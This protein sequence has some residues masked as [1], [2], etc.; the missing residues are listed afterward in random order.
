MQEIKELLWGISPARTIPCSTN[1]SESK[2]GFSFFS[3]EV[4]LK[5][6]KPISNKAEAPITLSI[7]IIFMLFLTYKYLC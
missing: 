7:S 3:L 2:T 1:M 5:I 4:T 6:K